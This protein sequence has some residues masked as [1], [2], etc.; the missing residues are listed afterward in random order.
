M[1][2]TLHKFLDKHRKPAKLWLKL[3]V[4]ALIILLGILLGY[5]SEWLEYSTYAIT[6]DI[7]RGL[8]RVL[9][10]FSVWIFIA[11]LIAYFS[12]GPVSSGLY[13]FGFLVAMCI[14]YFIPKH[15]HYGYSVDLQLL[16]W[17][18]I[19]FVSIAAAIM[20]WFS[21]ADGWFG[22]VVKAFPIAA[23]LSEFC[24]TVYY[25]IDY[26]KPIPG[27]PVEPLKWLLQTDCAIQL[28]FYLLFMI[29]LVFALEKCKKQR[30]YISLTAFS[31][32]TVILAVLILLFHK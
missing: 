8:Q 29:V 2:L 28:S 12:W 22:I 21:R 15:M 10:N 14:A 6:N 19:A 23:I 24:Y 32:G 20:I 18:V 31:L 1:N 17:I 3:L 25:L 9:N 4:F 13:T 27:R 11:T 7:L 30:L 26:T 16:M 5:G